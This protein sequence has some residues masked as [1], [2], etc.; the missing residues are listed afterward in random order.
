MDGCFLLLLPLRG[1]GVRVPVLSPLAEDGRLQLR[2][3]GRS[4]GVVDPLFSAWLTG[5]DP[6]ERDVESLLPDLFE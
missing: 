3:I 5:L 4:V 1:L 2:V 6:D